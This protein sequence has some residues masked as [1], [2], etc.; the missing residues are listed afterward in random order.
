M[1][2]PDRPSSSSRG[3]PVGNVS[4]TPYLTDE[5]TCSKMTP[6]DS[7]GEWQPS[8]HSLPS[9]SK[10]RK[11]ADGGHEVEPQLCSFSSARLH[12]HGGAPMAWNRLKRLVAQTLT[13]LSRS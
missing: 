12:D 13:R 2:T 7:A 6:S 11:P 10:T 9:M 8:I 5:C 4:W 1:I 3:Q